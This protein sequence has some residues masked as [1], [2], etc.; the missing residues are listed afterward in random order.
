MGPARRWVH[1]CLFSLSAT[2][3]TY[4]THVCVPQVQPT[5]RKRPRS[6]AASNGATAQGYVNDA[7]PRVQADAWLRELLQLVCHGPSLAELEGKLQE[8][9]GVA[10]EAEAILSQGKAWVAAAERS[11]AD[12]TSLV[13]IDELLS[14]AETM[15]VCG[16]AVQHSIQ[17]QPLTHLATDSVPRC[18]AHVQGAAPP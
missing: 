8:Q 3:C 18:G 7:A 15:R 16:C 11:M 6:P 13:K 5:S 12:S 9:P 4:N 14:E 1:C 17:T 2:L 10:T